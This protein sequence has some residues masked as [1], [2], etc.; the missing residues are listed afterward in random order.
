MLVE[1]FISCQNPFDCHICLDLTILEEKLKIRRNINYYGGNGCL[2][3]EEHEIRWSIRRQ[4]NWKSANIQQQRILIKHTFA[5]NLKTW[6]IFIKENYWMGKKKICHMKIFTVE[7]LK[8]KE[9]LKII[10]TS[11]QNKSRKNTYLFV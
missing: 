5:D 2:N 6:N 8:F 11:I 7:I 4:G 3:W 9:P 10:L 1:N